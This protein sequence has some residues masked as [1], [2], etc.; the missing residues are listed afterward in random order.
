MLFEETLSSESTGFFSVVSTL[1]I[2]WS[3]ELMKAVIAPNI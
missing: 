2:F 3:I 1:I